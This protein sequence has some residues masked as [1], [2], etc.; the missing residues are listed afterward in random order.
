MTI[1]A[2]GTKISEPYLKAITEITKENPEI[3]IL[4]ADLAH[5]ARNHKFAAEFPGN[6]LQCGI[7]EQNMACIAAGISTCGYIPLINTFAVFASK[8]IAD[9]LS[10]SIAY[11]KLNVKVIGFEGGLISGRN[12]AT[13]QAIEDLAILRS[14][15]NFVVLDPGDGYEIMLAVKA[16]VEHQ[17]PV[18]LRMRRNN[19]PV[20]ID[21]A[22]TEFKIGQ[23]VMIRKG[24]G[25][26][27]FSTGIMTEVLW[28]GLQELEDSGLDPEIIHLHTIKP[29]DREMILQSVRKTGAAVSVENHTIY[30]GLGSAISEMLVE[31]Y[32]IPL[33]KVGIQDTFGETGDTDY[34]LNKYGLTVS[35]VILAAKKAVASKGQLK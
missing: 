28:N 14:I 30:G 9:Q 5:M 22:Q 35:Q 29:L 2:I 25:V 10:I 23:G 8:R 33:H 20:F 12:G 27:I 16:A 17:G 4:D 1:P 7:A 18:Y 19:V 26:S 34:L 21:W 24:K 6:H 3:I 32:P 31:E 11:P 15:P 13:H